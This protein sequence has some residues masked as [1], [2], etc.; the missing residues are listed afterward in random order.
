[1][2]LAIMQPYL[3]PYLGYFQLIHATDKFVFYDDVSFI[4][5]GW[6]NRNRLLLD[7]KAQYFT[8][9]VSR[10]S[11]HVAIKDTR[12][13]SQDMRWRRKFLGTFQL[14]YKHAPYFDEGLRLVDS[15]L[16]SKSDS[17]AVLARQSVLSVMEYLDLRREIVA[18]S[19]TYANT[20]LKGQG[21]VLDI[22]RQEGARTYV[23]AAGGRKLYTADEFLLAG[24]E[25]RFLNGQL[26]A[27]SQG[28]E[29]FVPG[30]SILD[31][32][33]HCAPE[34]IRRMLSLYDLALPTM[35]ENCQRG[36]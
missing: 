27:Y 12:F 21:R 30:L 7:G 22:C 23:N 35:S 4:K 36:V 8:V 5:N 9:P 10:A 2:K 11:S 25:L 16:L 6:I 29:S 19:N 26:P 24:V 18:T 14:A 17:I 13:K 32:I 20:Q 28:C 15:V 1:M 3:F 34:A 33:M 31:I